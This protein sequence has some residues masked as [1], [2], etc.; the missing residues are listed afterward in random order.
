MH[1]AQ[2]QLCSLARSCRPRHAL[3]HHTMRPKLIKGF[4]LPKTYRDIQCASQSALIV[5]KI[6]RTKTLAPMY[7]SAPSMIASPKHSVNV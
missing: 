2:Q 3:P 4:C 6:L 7:P 5:L 1:Y